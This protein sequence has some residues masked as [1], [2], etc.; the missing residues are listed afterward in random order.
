MRLALVDDHTLFREG[1]IQL[2]EWVC[3]DCIITFEA[4]DG[5]DLQQKLT[6]DNEPEIILMDIN[7]PRMDGY[8]CVQWLNENFPHVKII[9]VSMNQQEAAMT[10]ML[11]LGVNG[12][13][14]KDVE[15]AKLAKVLKDLRSGKEGFYYTS[16]LSGE[17]HHILPGKGD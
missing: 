17:L 12:Y 2:I 11:T 9:V 7:M 16:P 15:P 10:R 3:K 4:N 8:A 6:K 1:M 5:I 13:L 14:S